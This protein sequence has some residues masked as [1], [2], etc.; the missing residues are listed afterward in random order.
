MRVENL[1]PNVT[2]F[3]DRQ[4]IF[5]LDIELRRKNKRPIRDAIGMELIRLIT[6]FM[7]MEFEIESRIGRKRNVGSNYL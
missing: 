2:K 5:I 6:S 4:P 3:P 7:G 1:K